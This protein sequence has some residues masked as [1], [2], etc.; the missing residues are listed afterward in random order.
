MVKK[1][2]MTTCEKELAKIKIKAEKRHQ[3]YLKNKKPKGP[4]KNDVIIALKAQV[5]ELKNYIK[6]D[7]KPEPVAEQLNGVLP[8]LEVEPVVVYDDIY[9]SD[10]V[11]EGD[12]PLIASNK[13]CYYKESIYTLDFMIEKIDELS[14]KTD[15]IREVVRFSVNNIYPLMEFPHLPSCIVCLEKLVVNLDYV[16]TDKHKKK[17]YFQSLMVLIRRL[18]VELKP[19]VIE[20]YMEIYTNYRYME[21]YSRD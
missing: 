10:D 12:N 11:F 7:T 8:R 14:W 16:E 3:T 6:V 20:K 2:N 21:L 9:K 4:S 13:T 1:I 17:I 5:E 15:A 19:K 18:E